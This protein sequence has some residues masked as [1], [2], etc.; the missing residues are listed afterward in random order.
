M[1]GCFK[2][3][4]KEQRKKLYEKV[5]K[6]VKRDTNERE[7][8]RNLWSDASTNKLTMESILEY[9]AE[10]GYPLTS[11]ERN[12]I[13][14]ETSWLRQAGKIGIG[15]PNQL[16]SVQE[17]K[18]IISALKQPSAGLRKFGENLNYSMSARAFLNE[19]MDTIEALES[20]SKYYL[21]PIESPKIRKN[22]KGNIWLTWNEHDTGKMPSY[23]R[24]KD[25]VLIFRALGLGMNFKDGGKTKWELKDESKEKEFVVFCFD[26]SEVENIK[27]FRPGWG[28]ATTYYYWSSIKDDT[29]PYGHTKA[30]GLSK[31]DNQPE[32][33]SENKNFHI[34]LIS[35]KSFALSS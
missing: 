4:N 27:L 17:V 23:M 25:K 8:L 28:D 3:L 11:E 29:L 9:L 2:E 16:F 12:E 7:S 34:R 20:N 21:E 6:K 32:T 15:N 10:N 1:R 14:K 30:L 24:S 13:Y 26:F 19:I 18:S 5:L 35:E 31:S 33:V 22:P